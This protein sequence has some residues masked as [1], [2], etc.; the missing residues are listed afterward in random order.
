MTEQTKHDR[1]FLMNL[2][3]GEDATWSTTRLN[4]DDV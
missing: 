1:I 4:K 3:A 2:W